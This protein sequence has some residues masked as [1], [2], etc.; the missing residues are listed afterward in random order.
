M[1]LGEQSV[2]TAGTITTL[3]WSAKCLASNPAK[4]ELKPLLVK[5]QAPSGWTMLLV[6]GQRRTYSPAVLL[7]GGTRTAVTVKMQE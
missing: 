3:T 1:G 6:T 2:M 7:A 4:L 5:V